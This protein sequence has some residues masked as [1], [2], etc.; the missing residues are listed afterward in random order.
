MWEDAAAPVS[1]TPWESS[2]GPSDDG[3]LEEN[4]SWN[5][6]MDAAL[7]AQLSNLPPPQN[8]V[9]VLFSFNHTFIASLTVIFAVLLSL[10]I[11]SGWI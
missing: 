10:S 4:Q 9:Q 6:N 11:Q 8:S 5:Q 7:Q 2:A 1:S 3:N